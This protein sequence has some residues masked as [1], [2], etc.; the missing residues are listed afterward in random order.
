MSRD[1]YALN[2]VENINVMLNIKVNIINVWQN[3]KS[4][5]IVSYLMRKCI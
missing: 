5:V 2:S 1:K 3:T 4:K